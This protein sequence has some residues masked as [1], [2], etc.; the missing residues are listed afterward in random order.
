MQVRKKVEKWPKTGF[1]PMIC[2]SRGSKSRLA[3]AAGAEPSGEMRNEKLHAVVARSN[4]RSQ[5]AK[6]TPCPEHLWKSTCRKSARCCGP[7]HISKS[8]GI[9][10][11]ILGARY[12][13]GCGFVW[14]APG[15]LH[16]VKNESNVEVLQQLQTWWQDW[17]IW[18]GSAIMHL[19]WQGQCKTHVQRKCSEVRALISWE[20]LHFG[21]SDL[22]VC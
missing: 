4:F 17:G 5:N 11:T 9:K 7:K 8:K 20:R 1:F 18:R 15:I 12:N 10:H 19:A 2:G 14:Q 22:Q 13:L 21:A 16:L 3:K 6:N